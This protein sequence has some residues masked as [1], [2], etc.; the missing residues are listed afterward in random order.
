MKRNIAFV[1]ILISQVVLGQEA[2]FDV[3]D[4]WFKPSLIAN[5]D[6]AVCG[7]ILAKYMQYFQSETLENPLT[8]DFYGDQEET[9]ETDVINDSLNEVEWGNIDGYSSSMRIAK[10]SVDGRY[11]ALVRRDYS[12]G[13]R[14]GYHHEIIIDKPFSDY[15]LNESELHK[16]FESQGLVY[17]SH[18]DGNSYEIVT[19]E[20]PK[21]KNYMENIGISAV[22]L[23]VRDDSFYLLFTLSRYSQR[24]K[25]GQRYG[26]FKVSKGLSLNLTC[27]IKTLPSQEEIYAQYH[28]IE[29]MPDYIRLLSDMMGGSG[30][31]GT[32]NAPARARNSM[33]EALRSMVYRPWARSRI[34]SESMG[35]GNKGNIY[36]NLRLWGYNGIWNYG[37]YKAFLAL[38]PKI[39][40]N[41]TEFYKKNFS[42]D[43]EKAKA[44]TASSMLYVLT[45]AFDH[46]KV[47][48]EHH[49]LHKAILD[50]LPQD[51]F[52][53]LNVPGDIDSDNSYWP[54]EDSLL[55]FAINQSDL[56]Q[57]LLN[58]GLDINKGNAFNKTPLMYAAQYNSVESARIL[59]R[60]G[61]DTEVA[62]TRSPDGCG[63]I[64]RTHNVSALHYAVRYASKEFVDLLIEYGAS[65]GI[66]DS[67]GHTAYDYLINYG[68]KPGYNEPPKLAYGLENGLFSEADIEYLKNVLAPPTEEQKRKAS[69]LEN[70]KGEELYNKNMYEEALS[71][72]RKAISI[73]GENYRAM[74]NF[75]VTALKLKKYGEA[76]KSAYEVVTSAAD[77]KEKAAA[78]FNLGLACE[79]HGLEKKNH[80]AQIAY[81]SRFYCGQ[82][83]GKLHPESEPAIDYFIKSYK[84]APTESRLRKIVS[85]MSEAEPNILKKT[86]NPGGENSVQ[87]IY[88]STRAIY[89]LVQAGKDV[90]YSR[91]TLHNGRKVDEVTI[92]ERKLIELNEKYSVVRWVTSYQPSYDV[93]T[94]DDEKVCSTPF[95]ILIDKR[96]PGALVYTSE[97]GNISLRVNLQSPV[98]LILYGNEVNW[99]VSGSMEGVRG[100]YIKGKEATLEEAVSIPVYYD[101]SQGVYMPPSGSSFNS[102][103]TERFIGLPI[104]RYIEATAGVV[105]DDERL[106][107]AGSSG[108]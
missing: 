38:R 28:E 60:A 94:F 61:A 21:R 92:E 44:L 53:E 59:L 90:P 95:G 36:E 26:L 25:D 43:E 62:T 74:S 18:L 7:Q 65:T 72:F 52:K 54:G 103:Y 39:D 20:H 66:E 73:S 63:N 100:I 47:K 101:T 80:L 19:G 76:A 79:K 23:Y 107:G 49:A 108:N 88:V 29:G 83:Y 85:L 99:T 98:V 89:F 5:N 50:G 51:K 84:I 96:I 10:F 82:S 9:I 55:T 91:M 14:E 78:Y 40:E 57:F 13:W 41:L 34:N 71:S 27:E 30:S 46:G 6:P 70:L 11:Y 48:D 97:K 75:S 106:T 35:G 8:A 58:Q 93:I 42:L 15:K 56:I 31:C 87:A 3:S 69:E 4:S 64:I 24:K 32:L 16:Y 104:S 102:H 22:N 33:N 45:S 105:I 81:D 67:D 86:C 2:Q 68:G 37:K 12:I 77:D 1:L 17:L